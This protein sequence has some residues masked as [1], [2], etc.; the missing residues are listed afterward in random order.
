MMVV[1]AH[2][3]L[4][5]PI[6]TFGQLGVDI[7]F[8]ISGFVVPYSISLHNEKPIRSFIIRRFLRLYPLYWLSVFFAALVAADAVPLGKLLANLTMPQYYIGIP[9]L[10]G[11]YWTLAFELLFYALTVA[12]WLCGWRVGEA[13]TRVMLVLGMAAVLACAAGSRFWQLPL[14]AGL[15]MYLLLMI[16]GTWLRSAG[17]RPARV[18]AMSAAVVAVLIAG[19]WLFYSTGRTQFTWENMALKFAL[20]P[21][22]FVALKSL[23]LLHWRPLVYLGVISYPLYHFHQPLFEALTALTAGWPTESLFATLPKWAAAVALSTILHH[24]VE[25]PCIR[26]GRSRG[27]TIRHRAVA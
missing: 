16:Y 2:L 24:F 3:P 13:S 1:Y 12:A 23:P 6:D 15:L 21:V 22:L 8:I 9:G 26:L 19:C 18:L 4:F 20:A 27:G 7:F 11:V 14:P 25:A 10:L 17:E 5:G